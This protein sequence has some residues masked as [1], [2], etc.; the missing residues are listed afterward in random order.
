M[1]GAGKI[2]VFDL[3]QTLGC[4]NEIGIFWS[5]LNKIMNY[6]TNQQ[7]FEVMNTTLSPSLNSVS[8][9]GIIVY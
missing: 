6:H 1:S 4:F 5:A 8:P 2:V 3:D 9:L 7:F